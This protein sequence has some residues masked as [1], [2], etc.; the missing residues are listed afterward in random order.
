MV[1]D[2]V[3]L[4]ARLWKAVLDGLIAAPPPTE[5]FE[6]AAPTLILWGER[7]E[8]VPRGDPEA[9]TAAIPGSRLVTYAGTGHAVHWEQ[10][11]RV[12]RDIAAFVEGLPR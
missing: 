5:T 2:G 1:E 9:M 6:I 12:A 4:P 8:L 7:D 3:A 10:P 11:E